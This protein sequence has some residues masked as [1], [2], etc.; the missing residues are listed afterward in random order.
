MRVAVGMLLA[1]LA[2]GCM[3]ETHRSEFR[4][5]GSQYVSGGMGAREKP[6][7]SLFQR[8]RKK[9]SPAG[10]AESHTKAKVIRAD[11]ADAPD[12]GAK[13]PAE[14]RERRSFWDRLLGR[15]KKAKPV[16]GAEAGK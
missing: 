1:L 9:P 13:Q 11:G 5:D 8:P 14:A 6:P 16:P 15:D 2:V 12:A 4:P 7:P 3:Q 10:A